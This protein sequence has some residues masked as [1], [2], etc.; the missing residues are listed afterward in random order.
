MQRVVYV[1]PVVS[2]RPAA[3]GL[4]ASLFPGSFQGLTA[5]VP[6]DGKNSLS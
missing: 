3:K 1:S 2:D 5:T 4:D 6:V